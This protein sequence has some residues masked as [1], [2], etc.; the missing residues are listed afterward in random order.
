MVMES[1]AEIKIASE[2]LFNYLSCYSWLTTIGIGKDDD[3]D[4][5][6]AYV[7][8]LGKTEKTVIPSEWEG[9]KVVPRKMGN[10]R[11]FH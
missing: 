6:F 4:C 2:K 7:T 8:R 11:I 9:F 1:N 5:I 10:L 3:Q